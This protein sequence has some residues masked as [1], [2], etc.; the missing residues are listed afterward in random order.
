ML[1]F[2]FSLALT[3]LVMFIEQ[4]MTPNKSADGVEDLRD[5]S[6]GMYFVL[7]LISSLLILPI[8]FYVR[9]GSTGIAIGI[10]LAVAVLVVAVVLATIAQVALAA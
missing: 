6:V 3:Y 7:A 5:K 2:V 9:R 1:F 4:R 10:G 8:Y